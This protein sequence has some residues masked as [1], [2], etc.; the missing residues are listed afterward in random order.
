[1]EFRSNEPEDREGNRGIRWIPRGKLLR[2]CHPSLVEREE[3]GKY[4]LLW[5]PDG[6]PAVQGCCLAGIYKR[7]TKHIFLVLL[8]LGWEPP[9]S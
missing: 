7:E 8:H 2:T 3:T 4:A 6:V 5:I 1:M 9:P